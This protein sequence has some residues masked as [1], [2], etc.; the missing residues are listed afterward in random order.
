MTMRTV[1]IV[2]A[3]LGA[4]FGLAALLVP[5]QFVALFDVELPEAG[6]LVT[7]LFGVGLLAVAVID[8]FA[9]DALP[10]TGQPGT[11]QGIVIANVLSLTLTF[12]LVVAATLAGTVN[13][14][15]WANAGL[16][17]V[18]AVAW[19]YFGL[20]QRGTDATTA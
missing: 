8:W 14:L 6:L 5:A 9:R 13:A 12:I 15:G 3:A 2:S 11:E 10:G 1:A 19:L 20:L 4:L 7:R 18:I 17:A 16:L